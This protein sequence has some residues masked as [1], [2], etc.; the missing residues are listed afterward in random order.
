MG[1]LS[2]VKEGPSRTEK[3]STGENEH[4][5][6]TQ[7]GVEKAGQRGIGLI[8]WNNSGDSGLKVLTALKGLQWSTVIRA[9]DTFS[10]YQ[11]SHRRHFWEGALGDSR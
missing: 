11:E 4:P 2:T 8:S 1:L 6:C 9:R 7:E 5:W 3:L 10:E